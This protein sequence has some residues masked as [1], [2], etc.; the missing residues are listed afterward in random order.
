MKPEDEIFNSLAIYCSQAERCVQ[1]VEKKMKNIDI[2]EEEKQKAIERLKQ[3]NFIDEKRFSR[4]FV[5]DKFRFNLWGRIKICYELKQKGI[6][7]EIYH[8]AVEQIDEQEYL[9]VLEKLLINKK[10]LTKGAPA[11]MFQKIYRFAFSKGFESR[12][13]MDILKKIIEGADD[14]EVVE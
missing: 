3:E 13:V 5:A 7:P 6:S 4:S 9:S 14:I 1:D 12:L 2:T 8:E 11:E 10:R